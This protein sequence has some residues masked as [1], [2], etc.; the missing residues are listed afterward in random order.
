MTWDGTVFAA[1][2]FPVN[3]SEN[4][5]ILQCVR[6]TYVIYIDADIHCIIWKFGGSE[7]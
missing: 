4:L 7:A 3:K 1:M 5:V 2:I 6:S